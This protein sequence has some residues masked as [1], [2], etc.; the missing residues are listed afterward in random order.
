MA[1]ATGLP[2]QFL[3]FSLALFDLLEQ[4]THF[5]FWIFCPNF[6]P[7]APKIS[8]N[9]QILPT[10]AKN[11]FDCYCLPRWLVQHGL[12][13]D[14]PWG[15]PTQPI[16]TNFEIWVNPIF[17]PEVPKNGQNDQKNRLTRIFREHF[18]RKSSNDL[19]IQDVMNRDWCLSSP[20][21]RGHGGTKVVRRRRCEM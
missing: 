8:K 16:L 14:L 4:Y 5:C 2:K 17:G 13:F 1:D 12:W 18:A 9:G 11:R 20:I 10:H 7:G 3:L 19:N 15:H 6:G 21:L